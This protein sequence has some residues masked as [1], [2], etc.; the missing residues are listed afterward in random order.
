MRLT[1]LFSLICIA[2]GY[3]RSQPAGYPSARPP[4]TYLPVKPPAPPPRPPP[5]P[6]A[7]SYGPPKKG[8]GK[9]PP[10]PPKPSYGPPPKNGNGK[11]PP[12]NAYLPP[13][14]GNGGPSGGAGGG[15]GEDIPIIK[16]ESKV[17]TDGSYMYE[18]ETGNGIKAEEMG[19]LKNAGVAG[20]EAQTAE[21]SFSYTSP[22]GQE[23]SL[24]YIA[25]ENGFQPQG[26]H[27]PTP[28]PIP[29]EIQE[30]LDKL[31]AGGGCHGCDDNET[32]GNDDGGGGG[33]V[34]RRK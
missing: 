33:Y 20:A 2:I 8:N 22:E 10:A 18:Y 15:G 32:G 13:G 30:A 26:D 1:T 23:I 14:N 5:P 12:S 6:P 16:L 11:P 25:D 4:A 28:P 19:Y 7:N 17:N 29:I 24:T 9:P 21:G 27:L 34:Y 31:A 3:V